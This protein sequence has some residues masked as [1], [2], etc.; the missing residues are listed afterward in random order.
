MKRFS[1]LFLVPALLA[2]GCRQNSS[3][4]SNQPGSSSND[5]SSTTGSGSYDPSAP[6]TQP[7]APSKSAPT[8]TAP[9]TTEP[10]PTTPTNQASPGS[11]VVPGKG[12][13]KGEATIPLQN[14]PADIRNQVKGMQEAQEQAFA[15]PPV[16]TKDWVHF[17]KMP[18]AEAAKAIA[19]LM[20][21][22][23]AALQDTTGQVQVAYQSPEG[24]GSFNQ[25]LKIKN[26]SEFRIPFITIGDAPLACQEVSNGKIKV[27]QYGP[28]WRDKQPVSAPTKPY[29]PDSAPAPNLG[30]RLYPNGL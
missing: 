25:D 24:N 19:S 1:L 18:D 8:A 12:K 17:T 22:K 2:V 7:T 16:G 4:A 6:S 29:T 30:A 11:T 20:E 21:K 28:E 15:I 13:T 27:V 9:T 10:T 3:I 23:L 14:L 5:S 26:Y